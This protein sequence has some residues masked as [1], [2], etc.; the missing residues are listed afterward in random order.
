[1]AAPSWEETAKTKRDATNELIPKEWR[2]TSPIPP[3]KEQRDVTGKYILQYL[4]SREAEITESDVVDIVK[5]T[6]SGNWTAQEVTK[7][8]C[9]RAALAH[10]LVCFTS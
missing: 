5:A 8:F 9:H 6:S 7:A 3:A 2:L 1:M 10:Q 4:S